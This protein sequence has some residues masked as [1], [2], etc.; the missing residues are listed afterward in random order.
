MDCHQEDIVRA[1]IS[2]YREIGGINHVDCGNL[3]S[4][5]AV[6]TL[7][8]DLLHIIF[9][10]FFS[11]EA[12]TFDE[13]QMMTNE[14]VASVRQRL[15]V[16]VRRSLRLKTGNGAPDNAAEANE[17]VCHFLRQ[18][19]DVRVLLKTDVQAAF[20]GDPAAQSFEEIILAYPGLEA[21]A[22]QRIAHLLYQAEVPLLPR[23][24]TEWAH[25]R[26]GIDIHPGAKIGTHFF[27]DH[28]TGVVIGETSVIGER[29]RLYQGVTLGAKSFPLDE[30]G[31]PIKGAPRHPIVEDDVVIYAGATVLGRVTV[32][33]GSSIGGNVWLTRSV[34]PHSRITQAQARN[35]MFDE[36]AGI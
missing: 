33:R 15:C 24:M 22:V 28:G 4:K 19:P 14:I 1:L 7:C 18:L 36:G 12:L 3:P 6:A 32:G 26:T 8:E 30:H 23:M 17:L 27:I 16:E 35:E 20:D 9:P 25:G 10:G 34:P 13:L 5:K 2:S 29:V 11:E 31:A 21:I